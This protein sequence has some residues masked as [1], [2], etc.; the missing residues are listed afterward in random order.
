MQ[1]LYPNTL[2]HI[3][4]YDSNSVF[5][6]NFTSLSL[7]LEPTS[8][9]KRLRELIVDKKPPTF[10]SKLPKII[11]SKGPPIL[12]TLNKA[13]QRAVLKACSANDY[14]LI[15][16]MPGAGIYYCLYSFVNYK[17]QYSQYNVYW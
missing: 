3:D 6:F 12:K 16:G 15:K 1:T 17:T 9:G 14:L 4:S 8:Q 13:Q 11:E 10:K 5:G 2:F 7:I